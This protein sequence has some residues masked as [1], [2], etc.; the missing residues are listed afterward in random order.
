[1]ATSLQFTSPL[2]R[3]LL[4]RLWR[5]RGLNRV[6]N[7]SLPFVPP[8]LRNWIE[9]ERQR[10]RILSRRRLV[11][12]DSFRALLNHGLRMISE[13]IGRDNIGAYLEFGVY[14]GT[15][16]IGAYHETQALGLDHVRLFG[17]DSFEG[18]PPEAATDDDGLC[19]C[20]LEFTRAVLQAENV[21]LDRVTLVP[22]WFSKTLVPEAV[23][24]LGIEKASVIMVDCDIYSSTK[25]ALAFCGPLIRDHALVLFDDWH[26]YGAS[27]RNLGE[28]KAFMEFLREW[29]CFSA[30][31]FGSYSTKAE[32]FIVSRAR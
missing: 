24:G 8:A 13:R 22:G 15:S 11:S 28:R 16:M 23:E 30:D 32:A 9:Q 6:F 14:N 26:A 12:I 2:H 29:P 3:E 1:V 4:L 31:R 10:A 18:L 21:D 7:A 19:R 27:Q 25:Q 5:V 17:F 20:E